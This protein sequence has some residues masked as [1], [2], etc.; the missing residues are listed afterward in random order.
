MRDRIYR[1]KNNKEKGFTLIEIIV[2]TGIFSVLMIAISGI[3]IAALRAERNVLASKKVLGELSYV[4]EYMTRA[5][6]MAD[7]DS[8]GS[9]IPVG[10]NYQLTARG[11]IKF[12]N[13]LQLDA[14]QEFFV[15]GTIIKYQTGTEE[16]DL[17]SSDI[18]ISALN[19]EIINETE[20]DNLQPFV[21][22]QIEASAPNSTT[23]H[24]QTSV[25]QRNPD[26]R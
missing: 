15:D 18:N 26:I 12:V 24:L 22:M 17:T 9:C 1:N 10:S 2:V 13:A 23:L 3:F 4:T 6:R 5:L 19:F 21:T 7:K 20:S 25:S 14:C 8:S 16:L 11:G